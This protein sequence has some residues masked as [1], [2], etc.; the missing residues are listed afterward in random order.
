MNMR[1]HGRELGQ[2][3]VQRHR[4]NIADGGG[5]VPPSLDDEVEAILAGTAGIALDPFDLSTMFLD[6]AGSIPAQI[7]SPVAR[8]NS[9]YGDAA[10]FF[11]QETVAARPALQADG[12]LFDGV[13]DLFSTF[14]NRGIISDTPA[15][16]WCAAVTKKAAATVGNARILQVSIAGSASERFSV[17][18]QLNDTLDWIVR[19]P[20]AAGFGRIRQGVLAVD[21]RRVL[22]FAADFAGAANLVARMNGTQVGIV[23]YPPAGN[24]SPA[25]NPTVAI[26]SAAVCAL[27]GRVILMPFL[28]TPEQV[29]ILEAWVS[30]GPI[31][32]EIVAKAG[33]HVK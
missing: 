33:S 22:L 10:Q 20:D 3:R 31:A 24:T 9:K 13:D 32:S 26:G 14:S 25:T 12:L 15:G 17:V 23:A 28:P 29:D 18:V 2:K 7:G 27:V 6:T 5:Y 1:Y 21:Q 19:R 11:S 4:S 8:I 30:N 16:A